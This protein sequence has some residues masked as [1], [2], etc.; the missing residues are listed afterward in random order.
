MADG[1][2]RPV[3]SSGPLSMRM[4]VSQ[5]STRAQLQLFGRTRTAACMTA[6]F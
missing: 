1:P 3:K 4:P 6:W 2:K 5:A